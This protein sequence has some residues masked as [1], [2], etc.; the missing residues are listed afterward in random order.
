MVLTGTAPALA[1]PSV[2]ARATIPAGAPPP[3]LQLADV[4]PGMVGEAMTVFQGR[5]PEP[6]K[7]RV[8]SVLR[9]FL[10][11]QDVILVRAED[12]RLEHTG[13][14][15]GMSGSPVYVGGKLMGAIA[16]GWSFAKEP[17]GGVTPIESMLA[18]R[19]RPRRI[20]LDET[21]QASAAPGDVRTV[22]VAEGG[23]GPGAGG[24]SDGAQATA[25]AS[26]EAEL[27]PIAIPLS[28]SG[29][30]PRTFHDMETALRPLGLVPMQGGGGRRP[31]VTGPG[32]VEPGSAIGVELVRGD[33]SVVGTGTVTYV[34]HDTVLAFGHPMTGTGELY[35]PLVDAEIHAILPSLA[36]SMKLSSPLAEVGALMQDRKSCILGNLGMR[37]TM[38][39]ITVRVTAPGAPERVFHA[40]VARHRRLTPTLASL[41]T[42]SAIADAEPDPTDM[43][44]EVT[45]RLQLHGRP[46]IEL[47][48]Q[49]ASTEG[50]SATL[51]ASS[52]GLRAVSDLL[53]NPFEPVVLDKLDV[54]VH[55]E[56]RRDLAEIVGASLVSDTIHVGDTV[57]VA[58]TLRPYAGPEYTE[59]VPFVVPEGV[60]GQAIKIEIASGMTVRPDAATPESLAGLLANLTK[61]FPS[62]S[63]VV[64]V[65]TPED[66]AATRGRLLRDLP[67]AALDTLRASSRARR[68]EPY[69]ITE[70][71]AFPTKTRR[72]VFGKQELTAYVDA[73]PLGKPPLGKR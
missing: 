7:V 64:S 28:V 36:Q 31:E 4:R 34:D 70:K 41:V 12:P 46:A 50:V 27:R 13:I 11:K 9:N 51:L 19:A 53:A 49:F 26:A 17:L 30:D 37:V 52:R 43:L 67:S 24:D 39:P 48:D 21:P 18:E 55:L 54:D 29:F 45:S 47:R 23:P 3:I 22:T 63:L 44:V 68:F 5:K 56:F 2:P 16:Y 73:N 65:Q 38:V 6:F 58:V 60:G 57:P 69:R 62:T 72:I 8:I 71:T 25:T 33:M 40:E 10:P 59:T 66:G 35:L 61:Y 20:R 32:R 15:A 42:S 14:V 1:A